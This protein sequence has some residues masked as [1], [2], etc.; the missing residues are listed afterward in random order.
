MLANNAQSIK[1]DRDNWINIANS[2]PNIVGRG[3][4]DIPLTSNYTTMLP[5]NLRTT[6]PDIIIIKIKRHNDIKGIWHDIST[7]FAYASYVIH[8]SRKFAIQSI[9][10]GNDNGYY[11]EVDNDDSYDVLAYIYDFS[12]YISRDRNFRLGFKTSVD[13]YLVEG[14]LFPDRFVTKYVNIQNK[15]IFLTLEF[16]AIKIL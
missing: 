10:C 3:S 4:V 8:G 6:A 13:S 11:I 16:I 2:R 1:N 15:N 12:G 7:E 14:E 5:F 9:K